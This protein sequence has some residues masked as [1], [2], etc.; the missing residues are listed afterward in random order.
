MNWILHLL[1][2]GLLALSCTT[3]ESATEDE[4]V[5]EDN[6]ELIRLY[7]EDQGDRESSN[8]D[9]EY[10]LPR[11]SLR[12]QRVYELLDAGLVRTSADYQNAAMIFQHG[13]DTI[14]SGMAIKLM[15][16][17]IELDSTTNKWLLAAAID[18]DLMRRG[19]PQIYG[20]QFTK[21][22]DGPWQ[23]YDIDTTQISDAER[24]AFGVGTLAE[25][26]EKAQ[27]L[28]QREKSK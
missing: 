26:R 18:R 16:K 21:V 23:L 13:N 10:L 6:P 1:T 20:T 11:D 3:R 27:I 22:D 12:R 7:E 4:V 2:D 25:Q 28:N 5:I 9:W 14:A 17:A 8:I 19:E 24:V 15:R